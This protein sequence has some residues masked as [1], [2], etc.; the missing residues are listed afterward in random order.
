L[1]DYEIKKL[2]RVWLI[3]TRPIE[4]LEPGDFEKN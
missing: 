2:L 4:Q 1:N 3:M